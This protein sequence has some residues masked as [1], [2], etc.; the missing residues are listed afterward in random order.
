MAKQLKAQAAPAAPTVNGILGVVLNVSG[1]PVTVNSG[2][3]ANIKTEGIEMGITEPAVLGTFL[4]MIGY[5]STTFNVTIPTDASS[6]PA[7]LA[8]I[9]SAVEN[10]NVTILKAHIKIPGTASTDQNTYYTLVVSV[11]EAGGGAI[12]SVGPIALMG[13]V[14]GVTN[15]TPPATS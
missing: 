3:I 15:E 6:L 12:V 7:P 2:T 9:V 14:V 13:A 8:S 1:K 5:I 4:E 11:N 10:L